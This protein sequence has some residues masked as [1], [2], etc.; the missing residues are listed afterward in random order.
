M[1]AWLL[2]SSSEAKFYW[3]TPSN[4]FMIF[5]LNSSSF[6]MSLARSAFC[7]CGCS[8]SFNGFTEN[9]DSS[10]EIEV[11]AGMFAF[12]FESRRLNI[13][14]ASPLTDCF[15]KFS[16][17]LS[18]LIFFCWSIGFQTSS[19]CALI[20]KRLDRRRPFCRSWA[21]LARCPYKGPGS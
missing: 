20:E 6:R 7:G 11:S 8:M 16:N 2:L 9:M 5:A 17:K 10:S 21:K 13:F 4:N 3:F 14:I 18:S 15:G 12:Y 1:I 19:S